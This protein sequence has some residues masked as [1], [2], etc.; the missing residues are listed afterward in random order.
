MVGASAGENGLIVSERGSKL[1]MP[2]VKTAACPS[3]SKAA[4]S[5]EN[6]SADWSTNCGVTP[7]GFRI[8]RGAQGRRCH[9]QI[10]GAR[11]KLPCA[12]TAAK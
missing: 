11:W 6:P 5:V 7:N 3:A 9:V 8:A 4:K 12:A 2:L 1:A 10:V